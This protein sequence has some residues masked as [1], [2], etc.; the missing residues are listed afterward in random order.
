MVVAPLPPDP[1]R[2]AAI[3]EALPALGAG[4]YLNTA[5]AGPLPAET[6]RAMSTI[7]AAELTMGRAH[8]HD[9]A[10]TLERIGEARASIAA[11]L[12]ADLDAVALTRGTSHGLALGLGAIDWRPGDRAVVLAEPGDTVGWP[13]NSLASAGVEVVSDWVGSA[14]D[15]AAMLERMRMF[16][17]GTRAVVLPDAMPGTGLRLPVPQIADRAHAMGALVLVDASSTVG[18]MALEPTGCGADMVAFPSERWL[19]GP[20]GLGGAWF[21]HSMLDRIRNIDAP[22]FGD[23]FSAGVED[24]AWLPSLSAVD[25]AGVVGFARSCGWL[26]MHVGMPFAWARTTELATWLAAALGTIPGV[27]VLTPSGQMAA[28]VT[29]RIVGWAASAALDELGPRI[30]LIAGQASSLDA[31]RLSVGAWTSAAELT[32]VVESIELL[33]SHTPATI[34]PRRTLTVLP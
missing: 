22:A 9:P 31:I 25:R 13:L 33:A 32:R 2:L 7:A 20:A 18:A 6:A 19:L 24:A 8:P 29:F 12:A 30:F 3:R 10:D 26:S 4:V 5:A 11:I 1:A 16:P 27:T 17:D 21:G 14:E 28:I 34:P 23:A 15:T